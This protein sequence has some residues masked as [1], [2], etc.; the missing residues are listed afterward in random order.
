MKSL[1]QIHS[2]ETSYFRNEVYDVECG[3]IYY[4]APNIIGLGLH[5]CTQIMK[6]TIDDTFMRLCI[7]TKA[8]K[9]DFQSLAILIL[10]QLKA[11]LS[12]KKTKRNDYRPC[13]AM[14]CEAKD[15]LMPFPN[16]NKE[17]ALF[18]KFKNFVCTHVSIF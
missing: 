12:A 11:N 10:K 1:G 4:F 5:D 7:M 6:A 14:F 15:H 8:A 18:L 9:H 3:V 13:E 2:L 16:R 17:K